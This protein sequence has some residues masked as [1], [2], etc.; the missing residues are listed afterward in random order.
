[1]RIAVASGKGGTGKTTIATN[2][3]R[4]LGECSKSVQYLDCD[5]E[6]P[7]GN[8]FLQSKI[9]RTEPIT[10]GV[11]EVDL[12]KCT[13]CGKCSQLC[14]YK[15]ISCIKDTVITFENLCHSCRGCM[16][17]CPVGAITEKQQYVGSVSIGNSTGVKFIEGRLK[18]GDI[19]SVSAIKAVKRYICD[20]GIS[21]ID[22]PPG[23]SCP[24]I[25]AV[26]DCDHVL[27]VT[28]CTP[29]GLND[30]EL[31][32]EMVVRLGLNFSI[33]INRSGTGDSRI[34]EFCES[35][36]LDISIELADDLN[37]AKAY[38]RGELIVECKDNYK[39]QFL[40]LGKKMG[41]I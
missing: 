5:V 24:V 3:A 34:R 12:N 33:V 7:N 31:A 35:R 36:K 29:F 2:L 20:E 16:L 11:P 9:D 17:V 32:V 15:S 13:R 10:V 30:L 6:E 28:E 8:I 38:S 1:M 22:A 23:T 25:E 21:I 27:L 14:Q 19:R 39:K 37:V 4:V 18:V 26:R 40:E 41:L